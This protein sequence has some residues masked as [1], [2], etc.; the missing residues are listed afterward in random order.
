MPRTLMIIK[1]ECVQASLCYILTWTTKVFA[2][3]INS[4]YLLLLILT[5][6][7]PFL[8][9]EIETDFGIPD[10]IIIVM[11]NNWRTVTWL[12]YK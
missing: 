3:L 8:Y 12:S 2:G 11:L 4:I 6:T 10:F 5:F 1:L 9:R 7:L